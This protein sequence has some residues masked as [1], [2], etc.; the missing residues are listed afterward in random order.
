MYIDDTD[1][2]GINAP[3]PLDTASLN[4]GDFA[5]LSGSQGA[6]SARHAKADGRQAET[7]MSRRVTVILVVAVLLVIALASVLFVRVLNAPAPTEGEHQIMR[8]QAG[9]G[10]SVAY[11]GSTYSLRQTN[12]AYSLVE[13][14]TNGDGNEVVVGGLPGEP[15]AIILFDGAVLLPENLPDG[16][17]DISVYTIGT[18]WS[19]V[20]G[21]DGSPSSGQGTITD[22]KLEGSELQLTVDGSV[23]DVPLVW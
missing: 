14:H 15:V 22:A 4:K 11:N 21:R 23:I 1:D 10:E 12:G 13:A 6:K 8:M 19:L 17:W 18:G 16:T 7:H 5:Q 2:V 9:P 3:K 20:S